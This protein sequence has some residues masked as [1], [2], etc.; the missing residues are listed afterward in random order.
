MNTEC[1]EAF[2]RTLIARRSH[3]LG[4]VARL[5][6]GL[7]WL[8]TDV[9]P[10]LLEAG[11]DRAL[12]SALESLDDHDRCELMA[13]D[14]ALE[15]IHQGRYGVCETCGEA[16]PLARQLAVPTAALCRPC[17]E[18]GEHRGQMRERHA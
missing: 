3:L 10:E 9:E 18:L 4:Q 14:Q 6:I 17:A 8:Q 12:A 2:R 5:D 15:R 1:N 16:I 13:I 7:H 11:Q